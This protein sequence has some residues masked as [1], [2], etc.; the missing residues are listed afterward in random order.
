MIGNGSVTIVVVFTLV[1]IG[2]LAFLYLSQK[3]RN[4]SHV[5]ADEDQNKID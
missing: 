5:K 3:K 2:A 1:S 4:A